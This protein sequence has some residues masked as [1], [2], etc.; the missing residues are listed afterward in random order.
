MLSAVLFVGAEA[1]L[2]IAIL[3]T[4]SWQ[5]D[6]LERRQ[7]EETLSDEDRLE[8]DACR[9]LRDSSQYYR[10][11][12]LAREEVRRENERELERLE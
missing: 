2:I 6:H 11:F 1:I 5:I 10:R 3:L 9:A 4:A 8:L 7:I 12:R